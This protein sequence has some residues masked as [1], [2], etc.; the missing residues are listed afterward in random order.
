[1]PDNF[2]GFIRQHRNEFE[3]EGPSPRVWSALEQELTGRRKGKVISLLQKNWFK[4]AVIAVLLANAGALFYF[5]KHRQ[6]QQQELA[7]LAPDIQEAGVYYTSRINEK[8]QLIDA[9]PDS[10]LGLDS[11]ARKEL[12]LRN[13]TYKA[14]EKELKNNPGN[15]R[16][17]AAMVR[18]YQLKL[19][20]LDKIL[21]ELHDKHV[22]PG[23]TKKHYEAEI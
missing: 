10:A 2:E 4:A 21:E 9:Y 18:Y 3:E 19:D 20:L 11:A 12:E 17:R 13:D 6:P 8:L 15:E 14:L 23:Q 22:A 16:I 7:V 1:M 5:T